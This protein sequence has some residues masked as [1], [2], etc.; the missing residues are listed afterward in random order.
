MA[1]STANGGWPTVFDQNYAKWTDE[2][3]NPY[4]NQWV[5]FSRDGTRIV[6]SHAELDEAYRLLAAA[7]VD[8][9]D[10]VLDHLVADSGSEL[11]GAQLW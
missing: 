5:F 9:S 10:T 6:A 1:D 7:G 3:L 8:P 4:A 11:G 2:Q